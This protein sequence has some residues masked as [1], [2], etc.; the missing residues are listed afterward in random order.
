MFKS[1]IYLMIAAVLFTGSVTAAPLEKKSPF[2]YVPHS[3][4][5]N[6]GTL[7]YNS[8][9]PGA[10]PIEF[11]PDLHIHAL[12]RSP[13]VYVPRS[14]M[15]SDGILTRDSLP[16]GAS[17]IEFNPDLHVHAFKRSPIV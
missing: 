5:N 6:D 17:P 3:G 13:F 9:P 4:G 1:T 16:P 15:I 7:T 14:G 8:L 11:D 2:V 10:S 12:K